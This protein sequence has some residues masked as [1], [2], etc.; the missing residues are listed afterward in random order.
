M[1]KINNIVEKLSRLLRARSIAVYG[2]VWAENIITQC[3]KNHFTGHIYPIHPTRETI[4]QLPVYKSLDDLPEIPDVAFVGINRHASI[5]IVKQLSS[6]NVGGAIC[7]ASGFA[8]TQDTELQQCLLEAA[9]EMPLLGP[10][11]YGFLNLLDNV[12][13]WPDQHGAKSVE[14]GVAIISQSSNIAIN[15]TMQKRGLPIAYVVCAGNQAQIDIA[16]IALSLLH[17]DRISCIGFYIEGFVDIEKF[18]NMTQKALAMGKRLIAIKVGKTEKSRQAASSHTA[19]MAGSSMSSSAFLAMCGVVEVP[20]ISVLLESL[21]IFHVIGDMKG[22]NLTSMSCSGGEAGLIADMAADYDITWPSFTKSQKDV[23]NHTLGGLADCVNPLDYQTFIWANEEALTTVY[24]TVLQTKKVNLHILVSDYPHTQRCDIADWII[25]QNAFI[26]A[27]K[28]TGVPAAI[29]S[30]LADN[31]PESEAETLIAQGIIPLCGFDESLKAIDCLAK[32]SYNIP[33]KQW[34][35]INNNFSTHTE[36]LL[37]NEQV[38]KE[39]LKDYGIT[40]PKSQKFDLVSAFINPTKNLQEPLVLKSLGFAHKTEN[41]AIALNLC[42]EDLHK[43]ALKMPNENGFILEEMARKPCAEI[44]VN[45]QRDYVYGV[46]ATIGAGGI[47]TELWKDIATIILPADTSRI[48][49]AISS[50]TIFRILKGYRGLAAADIVAIANT[51][52]SL[53][54]IL[55]EKPHIATIEINPLMVFSQNEGVMAVDAC[56]YAYT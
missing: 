24:R 13:I 34:K 18:Y 39:M 19:S 42:Y 38:S 20:S 11:C 2:G 36:T 9:G 8:E 28:D 31:M 4:A 50:L 15:I 10:N 41:N 43:Q 49:D 5:D 52:Q 33:A 53:L 48:I 22:R 51:V 3:T 40:V 35:K 27:V 17:D 45:V 26:A 37:I 54:Q 56:V 7:F 16:D 12:V 6:H 14:R 25:A 44:L 29:L 1:A 32:F 23:L 55:Y 21:K 30:S 47:Y 46:T